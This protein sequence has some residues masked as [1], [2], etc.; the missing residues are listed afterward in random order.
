MDTSMNNELVKAMAMS[1][2]FKPEEI[3]KIK[4]S[5]TKD[6]SKESIN[7][8][9]KKT[10]NTEIKIDKKNKKMNKLKKKRKCCFLECESKR[11]LHIA[12]PECRCGYIFCESH[13]FSG[14]HKCSVD[15]KSIYV[16]VIKK[17]NPKVI[18]DKLKHRI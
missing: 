2:E 3:T 17:Q 13:R 11:K 6:E 12:T 16:D 4:S 14:D 10:D 8:S 18:V 7:I 9:E 1:L 5:E 15:H